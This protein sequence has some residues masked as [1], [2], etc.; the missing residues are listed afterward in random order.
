NKHIQNFFSFRVSDFHTA[1]ELASTTFEKALK[2]LDNF[3]WQGVS[4]SA[5]LYRIARN[6]LIDYYRKE[7]R[8]GNT[9]SLDMVMEIPSD[10]DSPLDKVETM[11]AEEQL[12]EVLQQLPPKEKEIIYLKFFDGYTNK[13][14]AEVTGLSETNVG[15]IIYRTIRKLREMY[16]D[17]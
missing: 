4:F 10:E 16:K 9:S 6:T 12:Y 1:E 5:W 11:F 8:K 3:Q 14:I 17:R 15:T 2:S 7:N 13:V